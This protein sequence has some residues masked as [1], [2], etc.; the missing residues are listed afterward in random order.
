MSGT[1][2]FQKEAQTCPFGHLRP[3]STRGTSVLNVTAVERFAQK[4]EA[5]AE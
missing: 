4:A 1:Q 3:N 2:V 5:L